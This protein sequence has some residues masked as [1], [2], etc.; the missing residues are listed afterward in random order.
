[1]RL[2]VE[3]GEP[4]HRLA[5]GAEWQIETEHRS[6][7]TAL[8]EVV[9]FLNA[10]GDPDARRTCVTGS[11]LCE[12]EGLNGAVVWTNRHVAIRTGGRVPPCARDAE[13]CHPRHGHKS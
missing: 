11:L 12:R 8:G 2:G 6:A 9:H 7:Y 1:M 3:D 4:E 13:H 5:A 10:E